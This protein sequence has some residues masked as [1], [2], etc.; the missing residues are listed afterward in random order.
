MV[1]DIISVQ[2]FIVGGYHIV[3]GTQR[4][5][6]E[7]RGCVHLIMIIQLSG[8]ITVIPFCGGIWRTVGFCLDRM[9]KFAKY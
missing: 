6:V 1:D 4:A 5:V 2:S 7:L 9:F 8:R 3:V